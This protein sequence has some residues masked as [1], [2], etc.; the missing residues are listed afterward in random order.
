M[1]KTRLA[2]LRS[3]TFWIWLLVTAV[4]TGAF[5][6]WELQLFDLPL[7][8]LARPPATSFEL[9]YTA[10]LTLILSLDA[11]LFGWRRRHG[12]CPVGTRRAVGFAGALGGIALLCPVCLALPATFFGISTIIVILAPFL[13]L[14]R[15]IAILFALI[16]L[17]MLVPTRR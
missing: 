14:I 16:A 15:L 10:A 7:P 2:F 1:A 3:G 11:G 13:P 9:I 5:F 6:V 8:M 17:W 4:V 12:S